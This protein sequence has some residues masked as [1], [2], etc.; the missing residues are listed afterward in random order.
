MKVDESIRDFHMNVL[1][2]EN[3]SSVLGEKI[4]KEKLVRKMLR[5]LPKI[6]D[7]KVT[8]IEE[9]QDMN[10]MILDD[11]VGS[12]Q[13]FELSINDRAEK[14]NKSIDFAANTEVGTEECHLDS[15]EGISNAIVLLG[16]QFNRVVK[17]MG[18]NPRSNVKDIPS[19]T[20][21]SNDLG[22]KRIEEQIISECPTYIKRRKKI[23]SVT[24]SEEE[25]K[26][27][28]EEELAKYVKALR[29]MSSSNKDF[30]NEEQLLHK[31]ATSYKELCLRNT[32][33]HQLKVE[34]KNRL[35]YVTGL[36]ENISLL[37]SELSRAYKCARIL[38]NGSDVLKEI[39]QRK[40][41]AGNMSTPDL[42][43]EAEVTSDLSNQK[44]VAQ[45]SNKM[46]QHLDKRST[47][48]YNKK[49]TQWTSRNVFSSLIAHTSLR[50]ST[51]DDWYFD[52]GCSRHMTHVKNLLVDIKPH[53]SSYV[54][55]GDGAKDEIKGIRNLE[56]IGVPNLNN[57]LLVKGLTANLISIGQLCDQGYKVNFT[58]SECL[59][60]DKTSEVIMKGVRSKDNCYL[61]TPQ[62]LS[63]SSTCTLAKEDDVK[64]WH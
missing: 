18:R 55:F 24:W 26:S 19:D 34:N 39:P 61:W 58:K 1:E 14:K 6:F 38:N 29:S 54:T 43:K 13:T 15:D 23:L 25:S 22:R 52:S 46:S 35:K 28:P 59:V 30:S 62:E 20:Q 63:Y 27:D 64:I 37:K 9:A 53:S 17:Q 50:F 31:L 45:M 5:S 44:S 16:R 8:A 41:V 10:R 42:T 56:C 51:K 2:I 40:R 12:L 36:E 57:V 7:M 33:A 4:P 60:T 49:M 32:K 47:S 21:K 3:A 11:L 48:G